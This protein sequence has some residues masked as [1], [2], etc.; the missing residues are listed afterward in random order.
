MG[1]FI[2]I[3]ALEIENYELK[4]EEFCTD[5]DSYDKTIKYVVFNKQE[6]KDMIERLLR[7]L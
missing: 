1:N 6:I 3:K 5:E 7:C 2:D 4:T